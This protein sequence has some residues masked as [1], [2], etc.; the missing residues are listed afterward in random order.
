MST[1]KKV[2]VM[3]DD[4]ESSDY[5]K[6]NQTFNNLESTFQMRQASNPS[7]ESTVEPH[8]ETLPR[9]KPTRNYR[10]KTSKEKEEAKQD[11]ERKRSQ[12][13]EGSLTSESVKLDPSPEAIE[14]NSSS[15]VSY[16]HL[17]EDNNRVIRELLTKV[18]AYEEILTE[19][20]HNPIQLWKSRTL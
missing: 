8:A 9:E 1:Y 16:T 3:S 18:N 20:G 7:P 15:T 4:E 13:K 10:K 6:K 19:M 12:K 2:V 5:D 14:V 17:L 11:R